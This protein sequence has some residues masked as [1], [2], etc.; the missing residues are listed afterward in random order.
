MHN[1]SAAHNTYQL[2]I[3]Y[4][5]NRLAVPG[6]QS[7]VGAVSIVNSHLAYEV[8]VD[9]D[10]EHR[11]GSQAKVLYLYLDLTLGIAEHLPHSLTMRVH[12][13]TRGSQER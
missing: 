9:Q 1:I 7:E 3:I 13:I 6:A 10:I 5:R 11:A 4:D 12:D 8:A 2:T